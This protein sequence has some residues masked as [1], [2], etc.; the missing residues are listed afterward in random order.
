MET[1]APLLVQQALLAQ[2]VALWVKQ[3][4]LCRAPIIIWLSAV[5][6]RSWSSKISGGSR[7]AEGTKIRVGLASLFGIWQAR[8]RGWACV[9]GHP[10]F[11][12]GIATFAPRKSMFI[13]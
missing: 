1:L 11:I 8:K 9:S 5:S 6:G 2:E 7:S 3:G 13:F 4:R 10:H 12:S